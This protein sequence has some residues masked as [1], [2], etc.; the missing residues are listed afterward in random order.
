MTQ[1]IYIALGGAIG[2]VGRFGV[3]MVVLRYAG[4]G[5]PWGTLAVNVAGSFL[6]GILWAVLD[7]TQGTQRLHAVFMIGRIHNVFRVPRRKPAPV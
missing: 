4:G 7:Q 5:F 6:A 3:S 1:L 2:A